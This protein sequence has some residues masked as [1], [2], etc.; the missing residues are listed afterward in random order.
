MCCRLGFERVEKP[1]AKH[2][3]IWGVLSVLTAGCASVQTRLPVPD[4]AHLEQEAGQQER[5][6]FERY[7]AMLARLDGVSSAIL[8][9]NKDLCPKTGPDTG[10]ILHTK[11]SYPKHLR[12]AAARQLS[13]GDEP[14]VL[15]VRKQSPAAKAGIIAGDNLLDDKDNVLDAKQ[16]KDAL[17][18]QAVIR[19]RN[20][21]EDLRLHAAANVACAYGVRL[22]FSSAVNAYA[23]GRSIIV[24]TGMMDFIN[25]DAELALVIGHELAHN[26]MGHVRKSIQNTILSGFAT[27]YTRPFEAEADYVG[28][29]YMARAGYELDGVENFWH[30]L[31]VRHPKS[32]VLAKT[33][34]VTP[35]RSL[36]IKL[37]AEEIKLKKQNELPLRPNYKPGKEANFDH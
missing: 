5:L 33:H 34:P 20:S 8:Q 2:L 27:R 11:K 19:R 31:G 14:S 21:I 3:Y 7:E 12:D 24:T 23:T 9:A 37:S 6:A 30:R 10:L 29:Y 28:L 32:I 36:A 17:Q 18:N 26:T 15:M 22:K 16:L 25:S 1:M 4:I 35:E 13:A